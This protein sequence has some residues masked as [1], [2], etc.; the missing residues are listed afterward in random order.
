[1]TLIPRPKTWGPF[2][3]QADAAPLH[4]RAWTVSAFA[5]TM[6]MIVIAPRATVVRTIARW[7]RHSV[8]A[9]IFIDDVNRK[10]PDGKRSG[11]AKK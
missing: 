8:V 11:S 7:R 10:R 1:V 6:R 5:A 3:A 4:L 9:S 2:D